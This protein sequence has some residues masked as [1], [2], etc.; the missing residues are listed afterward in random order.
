M[1]APTKNLKI[2][3]AKNLQ[4]NYGSREAVRS[5]SFEIESQKC[6]GFLGPNGAGK[7]STLKMIYGA[8]PSTSG[9]L[10]ILGK[11]MKKE[12][13]GIKA[14]LGVI[15]QEENLDPELNV[16]ENLIVFS[17]YFNIPRKTASE[18]ALN[19]LNFFH[20]KDRGNSRVDELS[21][22]LKKRLL[23]ARGLIN[24]PKILILDEPTTGLDPQS[25]HII[26]EKLRQLKHQGLTIL[27]TT[28]YMEEASQL[29]DDI[30][31]MDHGKILRRGHPLRLIEE[32]VGKEIIE[33]RSSSP[34]IEKEIASMN[35]RYEHIGDVFYIYCENGHVLL[36]KLSQIEHERVIHRPA[37]LEDL[38]LKLTG[39]E[40]SE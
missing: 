21:S 7:S 33:I 17:R 26:W 11:E 6:F 16:L 19:L 29:C 27:L 36:P 37:T 34:M 22:G 4:K 5:I 3:L 38:F 35:L 40:L 24:E 30:V 18:K 20:L 31:I 13:R 14:V 32:E 12:P 8:I 39:R 9:T 23:I 1:Q 25:R 15:P 10:L 2:I 28:H